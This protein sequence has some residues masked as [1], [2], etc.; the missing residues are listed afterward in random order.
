MATPISVRP[1]ITRIF[2]HTRS[3]PGPSNAAIPRTIAPSISCSFSTTPQHNNRRPRRD[4]NRF[5]GLSSIYRSGT[6]F[7]MNID[8]SEVPVPAD[9]KPDINV[10]PNHGLWDFFHSKDSILLKPDQ[11]AEHGRAW[12]VEEL[13]HKSWED[14]H[15]LWW[16]CVKEQN[17]LFTWKLEHERLKLYDGMEEMKDRGTEVIKTMNAIKHT[18]TERWYLW[19][20]A[21]RLAETDPE[22]DLHNTSAPFQPAEGF[23]EEDM[24]ETVQETTQESVQQ[25]GEQQQQQEVKAALPVDAKTEL[26]GKTES[27]RPAPK[28]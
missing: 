11:L 24:E 2:I 13:R 3:F 21:R 12:S 9:Y 19:E 27:E 22:I 6:R 16:V 5:R 4:N 10:D 26:P 8:K 15:K 14:L 20:D 7:R 18:L 1:S 25:S 17:R 23:E 28:L